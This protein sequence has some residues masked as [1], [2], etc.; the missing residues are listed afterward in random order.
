MKYCYEEDLQLTYSQMDPNMHLNL[1]SAAGLSQDMIVKFLHQIDSEN[2]RLAEKYQAVWVIAKTFMHFRRMPSC[3][4]VIHCESVLTGKQRG[5]MEM[6]TRYT[7]SSGA[8]LFTARQQLCPISMV[9]RRPIPLEEIAFPD[10]AVPEERLSEEDFL[11][12]HRDFTGEEPVFRRTIRS[13]DIDFSH[14]FNNVMAIKYLYDTQSVAYWDTHRLTA[15]EIIF[16]HETR[17]GETVSVYAAA[18]TGET[19]FLL[20]NG[21]RDCIRAYARIEEIT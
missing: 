20:N 7:D 15:F 14:H 1:F 5:R 13:S 4:E 8:L 19:E 11:P 10:D 18:G 3:S 12:L 6:E 9:T 17:E 16:L 2:H 21:A